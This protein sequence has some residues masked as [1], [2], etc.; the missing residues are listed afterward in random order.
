[1]EYFRY[2]RI[3]NEEVRHAQ[4][5]IKG[6]TAPIHPLQTFH[7]GLQDYFLIYGPDI[8]ARHIMEAI[9]DLGVTTN[10]AKS[11]FQPTSALT[12]LGLHIIL[13][14]TPQCP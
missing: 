14:P 12:Y 10:R 7:C 9:T 11:V 8:L 3:W 4:S 6:S 13:T 1:M 5:H 2:H